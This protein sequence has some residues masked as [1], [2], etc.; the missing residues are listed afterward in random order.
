MNDY[1]LRL[2]DITK[3]YSGVKA[4]DSINLNIE[5]GKIHSIV[6]ENGAGKSTFIKI[7]TGAQKQTKGKIFYKGNEITHNNPYRS[8][9]NGIGCVY[10]E[11]NVIQHLT[12]CENIFYGYEETSKLRFATCGMNIYNIEYKDSK[13]NVL[14]IQRINDEYVY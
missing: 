1:I 11:L 3:E 10:Q 2:E 9:K 14:N 13:I 6:G 8:M 5:K 7:I 12:I 4:L